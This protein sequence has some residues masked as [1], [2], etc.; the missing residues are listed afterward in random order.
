M[1]T[2][3]ISALFPV[4]G[5]VASSANEPPACVVAKYCWKALPASALI[6]LRKGL[7][8]QVIKSEGQLR[9]RVTI[10]EPGEG[11]VKRAEQPNSGSGI[12]RR[13]PAREGSSMR[14]AGF[15]IFQRQGE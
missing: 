4:T 7:A 5:N 6:T 11:D 8:G 13:P 10:V 3:P 14:S 12:K 2:N 15:L 1:V 9:Y